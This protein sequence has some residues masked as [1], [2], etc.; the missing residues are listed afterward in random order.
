MI[1]PGLEDQH[2]DFWVKEFPSLFLE[3]VAVERFA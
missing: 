3:E 1:F 2:L